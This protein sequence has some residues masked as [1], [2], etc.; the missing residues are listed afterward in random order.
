MVEQPERLTDN[1]AF[2]EST[3]SVTATRVTVDQN[4]DVQFTFSAVP[5]L[6]RELPITLTLAETGDFLAVDPSTQT[7]ITLPANTSATN[8]YIESYTTKSAN[9]DFEAD[10]TVTLTIS[11]V[12]GYVVDSSANSASVVIHDADTP[13]GIS[14]LAISESV[15][16]DSGKTADFLIKSDQFSTSARKINV[17]IDDGVANFIANPGNS[18]ETIP[19]NSRSLLLPVRIVPDSVFEANGKI[20]VSILDAGG[21]SDTY[22]LASTDTTATVLVLDDDTP[23]SPSDP[24]AGISIVTIED[25]VSESGTAN[26]QVTAKTVSS[27][28]RTIRLMVDDGTADY[29]DI[30][31]QHSR[32]NYDKMTKVFLVTLPINHQTVTLSVNLIDDSKYEAN[33][34]ITAT[35][36]ADSNTANPAYELASTNIT[37]TVTVEDNDSVVP[38]LSISSGAAGEIGTGVTE[39]FSFKFK[40]RSNKVI[41]GS[42]LP[43]VVSAEDGTASLGLAIVGTKE[44]AVGSQETEFTVTMGSGADVA[45]ASNVSIVVS[46]AEHDD[47]DTNPAKESISI[48]VKDNDSP[49]VSNPTISISGPHYVAEG[50]TF[51]FILTPSHRPSSD[52]TVNVDVNSTQGN[53]LA[54]NQISTATINSGADQGRLA[55]STTAEAAPNTAGRITAE[56]IEGKGYALSVAEA[57]RNFEVV[58]LDALPVISLSAPDSVDEDD[59]TFDITLTSNITLV[60]NHP[61]NITTLVVDDSAGQSFDYFDSI[62]TTPIVID[63]SSLN[64][65]ITVPVTLVTNNTYNGWGEITATLTNG[66]DYTVASDA[67]TESVEIV[68]DDT[69]PHS[70]S[71]SAPASVVEGQSIKIKLV[72]SPA[73]SNGESLS[74]DLQVADVTGNYLNYSSIPITITD[75]NSSSTIVTIPT[76]DDSANNG[77]GEISLTIV[78]GDGYERGTIFTKNVTILDKAVLPVVTISA[79][80]AGPIDE[81]ETAVFT[82]SATPNPTEKI[83]VSVDVKHAQGTTG[84]FLDL[85]DIKV[86]PVS[87]STSGSGTL[88]ITTISDA[89]TEPS[90]SIQATL[91]SD[92]KGDLES[93]NRTTSS[94]YLIGTT[95][96]PA[97]V[98]ITDNDN[99]GLPSVT[100]SGDDS[101]GEGA[102]ATF[103]LA[104]DSIGSNSLSVSVR[105]TR[106]GSFFA[107]GTV[108]T[109]TSTY[110]IPTDGATPGRLEIEV[111]S[112]QDGEDE[113]D[114]SITARV[115]S[116]P[117]ATDTYSVGE[118]SSHITTIVDDDDSNLPSISISAGPKVTE[119]SGAD[120]VFTITATQADTAV[121]VNVSVQVS[122]VGNF[123]FTAAG[124]RTIPVTVG[125]NTPMSEAIKNDNDDEVDGSITATILIDNDGSKDYSLGAVTSETIQIKDDDVPI[126]SIEDGVMVTES[127]TPGSPAYAKFT[128]STP[129]EPLTNNFRIQYT[130][131][132]TNFVVDSGDKQTSNQLNFGDADGDNIFTAELRVE[133][134]SDDI[135]ETNQRLKVT[136]N[137]DTASPAKY[138]VT[139]T[140]SAKSA[141]VFVVDDDALIPEL[142][143]V[144]ISTPIA[145]SA[146]NAEFTILADQDPGREIEVYYTPAEVGDGDFLTDAVASESSVLV[147][148]TDDGTLVT[149]TFTVALD[150]DNIGEPTGMIKVSLNTDSALVQ[151]YTVV[152]GD[153][154]SETVT[155]LDNDA[156]TLT[157]T[158][159]DQLVT[160][161]DSASFPAKARYTVSSAVEPATRNFKIQYTPVS[162]N[163]AVNSGTKQLSKVLNFSDSDNDGIFEA[164]LEVEIAHDTTAEV[165]EDLTVTLNPD[166]VGS[167]KYFV[168]L[169]ASASVFVADNDAEI[170]E[171]S[172]EDVTGLVAEGDNRVIFTV[173]ADED[174]ERAIDVYYTPA[175]VD[176]GDFLTDAVATKT[177]ST[178]RFDALSDK[179]WGTFSVALD[180]DA[181]AEDNGKIKV[182]LNADEADPKTYTVVAGDASSAE[183]NILDN[184]APSISISSSKDNGVV[185]EGGNF[186][187]TLRAH[188][189]PDSTIT[190]GI[191]AIQSITGH[192]GTLTGPNSNAITLNSEG[193]AQVDIGTSGSTEVTVTTT[194]D[195]SDKRNGEISV[196]LDSVSSGDYSIPQNSA[197]H[198]VVV[199]IADAVAPIISITSDQDDSHIT[200]GENF[201]FKLEADIIPLNL[202]SVDL[203]ITDGNLGHFKSVTPTEPVTIHNV[204][205]VD[206]TLAT[207][208]TT[209]AT[210]GEIA[211][212]FNTTNISGYTTSTSDNSISVQIKDSV[213]PVVSIATTQIDGIVTEGGSFTFT[214]TA[215]PVPFSAISVDITA[216]DGGTSHLHSLV[217]SDSSNVTVA[218]DGSAEIGIGTDGSTTITVVTLDDGNNKRHGAIDISLDTV[219][220]PEA[221][222]SVSTTTS[223]Q[224]IQVKVKDKV[225]PELS[226]S[227]TSNNGKVSEGSNFTFSL[228]TSP[229]PI[230][231]ITVNI[232]VTEF[233]TTG[234]IGA[235]T[236]SDSN[237]ITVSNEGVAEIEIGTGGTTQITVATNNDTANQ[238]HGEIKIALVDGTYTDYGVSTTASEKV[239]QV[240]VEDLVA[241]VLSIS[242]ANDDS[243]IIE[244][245]SFRFR[246][247]AN[248]VPLTPISVKLEIDDHESGHYKSVTPTAPIAM[249]NVDSVLVTL[250][251]NDTT[252][253]E[254]SEI[255]VSI[256]TS[257]VTTYSASDNDA[258]SIGIEDSVKP[259]IS[260]SS[261]KNNGLVTEGG[262]FTFTLTADPAPFSPILIDV[263][264]VDAGTGH[265]G[266]LTDS[267]SNTISVEADGS[268]QVEIGTGGTAKVTVTT[269]NDTTNVRHGVI[270]VSLD[271][272]VTDAD[273]EVATDPESDEDEISLSAIQVKIKDKTAP[274][275]SISAVKNV[276]SITEGGSFVFRIEANIVPLT[277]I[278][279]KLDIDDGDTDHYSLIAPNG[280]IPMHNVQFVDVS[281][282]TTNTNTVEHG[283]IEVSID[284][285]NTT[286]Y[287]ASLLNDS[288]TMGI[289]DSVKPVVSISSSKNS[290]RV[291]EGTEFTFRLTAE[292]A[293]FN[294]IM[295]DI[296]AEETV[297]GHLG[298]SFAGPGSS[299]IS[300]ASDG[301]AQVEIGKDGSTDVTVNVVNDTN[302]QR[303][304]EIDVSLKEVNN[305][306]YEVIVDSTKKTIGVTIEDAKPPIISITS[307][308]DDGHI[309]EGAS[310]AFKLKAN[311]VP[312]TAISVDLEIEDEHGHFK[313]ITPSKPIQMDNV[314]EANVVLATND[315]STEAHGK[316]EVS[317][318][319]TDATY[320]ESGTNNSITV[321]IKD[322]IKP[323]VSISIEPDDKIVGEGNSFTFSLSAVPAPNEPILVD[324]SANDQDTG[325]IGEITYADADATPI[326]RELDGSIQVEIGISGSVE[327]SVSTNNDTSNKR[328]GL[329]Q[330]SLTDLTEENRVFYAISGDSIKQEIAVKI[331]DKIAPVVSVTTTNTG[332]SV[333]E[334]EQF[335]FRVESDLEILTPISVK[336]DISSDSGHFNQTTPAV[337]IELINVDFIEVT[338]TTNNTTAVEHGEISISINTTDVSTYTKSTSNSSLNVRIRDSVIPVVSITSELNDGVVTEGEKFEFIISADPVPVEPIFVEFTAVDVYLTGHFGTLSSTSPVEIGTEGSAKIIVS[339]NLDDQLFR[340][341]EIR[342]TLDNVVNADYKLATDQSSKLINVHVKDIVDPVVSITSESDGRSVT[343]GGEFDFS[344]SVSPAPVI[345]IFVVLNI[346]DENSGY[347]R[348]LTASNPVELDGKN[349]VEVT[350]FTKAVRI[351][352][353]PGSISVQIGS[354]ENGEYTVSRLDRAI[355]V[356]VDKLIVHRVSITPHNQNLTAVEGESIRFSLTV[357]PALKEPIR[358]S[359]RAIDKRN[360]GHFVSFLGPDQILIRT[361][362]YAEGAVSTRNISDKIGPGI[363]EIEILP[364]DDYEPSR[365]TGKIE[366]IVLDKINPELR[367][368]FVEAEQPSLNNP[369]FV[370]FNFRAIPASLE[371]I[372]VGILVTQHGGAIRWRAPTTI[373]VRDRKRVAIP[374]N[375]KISFESNPEISVMVLDQPHYIAGSEIEKVTIQRDN[376]SQNQGDEARVAIA[377]Q[378][379]DLVLKIQ[380]DN[381]L[382]PETTSSEINPSTR[383]IVSITAVVNT[384]QEGESA[385]FR[386]S[387]MQPLNNSISIQVDQSGDFLSAIPPTQYSLNG[388]NEAILNL[389]TTDDQIAEPD[390]SITVTITYGRDYFLAEGS[391]SASVTVT[392]LTDR[393]ARQQQ[394]VSNIEQLLPQI[395]QAESEI[396]N[397]TLTNRILSINTETRNSYFHLGGQ[398]NIQDLITTTGETINKNDILVRKLL[399]QS[400]F[401]LN[402]VPDSGFVNSISAWGQSNFRN[403]NTVNRG[404]GDLGAGELFNGQLGFDSELRPDLI[405]GLSTSITRTSIDLDSTNL[406]DIEFL[407]SSTQFNPYIGWASADSSSELRSMFGIGFGEIVANQRGFDS[408]SFDSELYSFAVNGRVGLFGE[409]ESAKVDFTGQTSLKNILVRGKGDFNN[410]IELN[411]RF[412]RLALEGLHNFDPI[413]GVTLS[414][415]SSIGVIAMESADESVLLSELTGG[416][417][418]ISTLGLEVI[419]DGRIYSRQLGQI[420]EWKLSGSFSYDRYHDNLGLVLTVSSEYC[421]NCKTDSERMFSGSTSLIS[422]LADLREGGFGIDSNQISSEIGYGVQLGEDIGKLNPF[423]AIEFSGDEITQRQIGGRVSMNSNIE[424]ELIGTHDSNLGLSEDYN[425]K[426]S[427]TLNW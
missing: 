392:D 374:V 62:P 334:G 379:A 265:L 187:F 252:A 159:K 148:F 261:T 378:V 47:Y 350:L 156:P 52:I 39:G 245:G 352:D 275:I 384:I 305:A 63:H 100:I 298:A 336:L 239:V 266:T 247:E 309:T 280:P 21:S 412:T 98:A 389:A 123:L 361:D 78:R 294:S 20:T 75:A 218:A 133:I 120:A 232:N 404:T 205:F 424:F 101:I 35:V 145:E 70:V 253:E 173:V 74:V 282:I 368:V 111:D 164:E 340:H 262:S 151:T 223:Q 186:T 45:P 264:A 343:E 68:D 224:A 236:D 16:E 33:G 61:I 132:S 142:S 310:F 308:Q 208:N 323:I 48:K 179:V 24:N 25:S 395:N 233:V 60:A 2:R 213:N 6:A 44:I 155:I 248:I 226:I 414:P 27:S 91:Q 385:K 86:H 150:N 170:P 234:H 163:F 66:L 28:D 324:L 402:V 292:P 221:S 348:A 176:G 29:I 106:A 321:G 56:I 284:D 117:L 51:D 355:R 87:V 415:N 136:L 203:D 386:I 110:S 162:T 332:L 393:A 40:V 349:P 426:F 36:L 250:A 157:I 342:V 316:I 204:K 220:D 406:G 219:T 144:S 30:D 235:L 147:S 249:D 329:I 319:V 149:G 191:T 377:S 108:L 293:P 347:F 396:L 416:F 371:D 274:V 344:L 34:I 77:N 231:A 37:A 15:T 366:V 81:G 130:P 207:N 370:V 230:S 112:V 89:I 409:Q 38:I 276:Q 195:T 339:T 313:E 273:Y 82:L 177:S 267:A 326:T 256:D 401:E 153:A 55:V 407:T 367:E 104:A 214:L 399:D 295:V 7:N 227:S 122:E 304:G 124:T 95:P 258:I 171:L 119:G 338:L 197:E 22:S 134:D 315:T 167:E 31:N 59:G 237:T 152:S 174:P 67:N 102:T 217:N 330:I 314:T 268:A 331:E 57:P 13:T 398:Q 103:T 184:D 333:T 160:E 327:I 10:S 8:T 244:G 394:I 140:E 41:T 391:S 410:E 411:S 154:N 1:D 272:D 285:T 345:P 92:P 172:L 216:V 193:S 96:A 246:I 189:A 312:L 14:V 303:H 222:Y 107:E 97:T 121:S 192:L 229:P 241:P 161:I 260:I 202:I 397:E 328:N 302:N 80:N 357:S 49:S 190:V 73:L 168:G 287:S 143:F 212:S 4:E 375:K 88:E 42:T 259:E 290:D 128:I 94:T 382:I 365:T 369:E 421:S 3:I 225:K 238:R 19:A 99:A 251:T 420:D 318:K 109:T 169:P 413:N 5:E 9:G 135:K 114:G 69:A 139:G 65:T 146:G 346:D 72:T 337:P 243:H 64:R 185:T 71:I 320:S 364:G 263:T 206:V 175:E 351:L 105:I 26:F 254:H 283:E 400:S 376:V 12:A 201:T 296:L 403:L 417:E 116:D 257:N 356:T 269:L 118:N 307:E 199:K 301:S 277:P 240:K 180:N 325:H 373:I 279:V 209:V 335:V 137:A 383:P 380:N 388:R 286:T 85:D 425:L 297:V 200:E 46:L 317:I 211:V 387:S 405:T 58:V 32:Y 408:S 311:I 93:V 270:D 353:D 271:D 183:A 358:V 53:F 363:I 50:S 322:T 288:I 11:D 423:V 300:L 141:T 360:T 126:L 115:L 83:M 419:G 362:G 181:R 228:S 354:A 76:R 281:L 18:I 54:P 23:S 418:Y 158:P 390:G 113:V 166:T 194:N 90:G 359:L 165:N 188:P 291:K 299:T 178:V 17:N 138:A 427:G 306:D 278:S 422:N 129:I 79:V 341:G 131:V 84:N 210:H 43:I 125:G 242:P 182:T 127:D 196:S 289:V 255:D 198:S 381:T 215:N 372:K